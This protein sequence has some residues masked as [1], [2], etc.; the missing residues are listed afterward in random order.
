MYIIVCIYD[1][2]YIYIYNMYLHTFQHNKEDNLSAFKHKMHHLSAIFAL[3]WINAAA[4]APCRIAQGGNR[5]RA[6]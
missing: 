5:S 3:M 1:Y 2:V 6:W 4:R